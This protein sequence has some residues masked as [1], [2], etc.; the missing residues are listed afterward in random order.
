MNMT[1]INKKISLLKKAFIM[2]IV[3]HNMTSH[4]PDK[5]MFL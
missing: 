2:T 1:E 4:Y 3:Y 5:S